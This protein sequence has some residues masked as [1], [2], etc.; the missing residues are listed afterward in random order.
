MSPDRIRIYPRRGQRR[1][2]IYGWGWYC[3]RCDTHGGAG[4][5]L[6]WGHPERDVPPR[7]R[8]FRLAYAHMEKCHA[9]QRPGAQLE[10]F[11]RRG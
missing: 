3:P 2:R 11:D 9:W 1:H 7:D 6:S 5:T 10:F 8:C 4:S